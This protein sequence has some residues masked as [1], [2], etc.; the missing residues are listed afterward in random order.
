MTYGIVSTVSAYLV[1]RLFL[2]VESD[3]LE[4]AHGVAE[5]P[6]DA[7]LQPRDCRLELLPPREREGGRKRVRGKRGEGRGRE[8]ERERGM[9]RDGEGWRERWGG[10]RREKGV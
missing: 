9:E 5:A 10:G 7:L 4:E 6:R 3:G 2:S 8:G 1:E